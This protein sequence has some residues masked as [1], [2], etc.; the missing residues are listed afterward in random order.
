MR[1]ALRR[2]KRKRK[3]LDGISPRWGSSDDVISKALRA[4]ASSPNSQ[5][6]ETGTSAADLTRHVAP[7]SDEEPH[8]SPAKAPL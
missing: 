2:T 4:G 7:S 3:A 8:G 1:A 5:R 6:T